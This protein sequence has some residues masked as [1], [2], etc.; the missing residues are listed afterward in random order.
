[1]PGRGVVKSF[2]VGRL[3]A[4]LIGLCAVAQSGGGSELLAGAVS[5]G[6]HGHHHAHSA[7][8]VSEDGHLH[9]VL[10]HSE[11]GH[12]G[13]GAPHD[14]RL[15]ELSGSDHVLHL[16]TDEPTTTSRRSD[17]AFAAAIAASPA[18]SAPFFARS[19]LRSPVDQRARGS[20]SPRPIVL[21]L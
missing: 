16:V 10:S 11:D 13:R 18:V 3:A 8:I 5:L 12:S 15:G 14:G 20:G 2:A 9:L 19:V 1:M 4:L 21:R 6:F 17:L 7:S